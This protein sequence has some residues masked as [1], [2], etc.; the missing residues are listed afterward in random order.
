MPDLKRA[1]KRLFSNRVETAEQVRVSPI[2]TQLY[3]TVRSLTDLDFF[4]IIAHS[5]S[6]LVERTVRFP[7]DYPQKRRALINEFLEL[8]NTY[9]R[10]VTQLSVTCNVILRGRSIYRIL[11]KN[12]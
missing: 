4:Q 10:G 6:G 8:E 2:Y 7:F 3:L 11:R 1:H 5:E 12:R 9:G